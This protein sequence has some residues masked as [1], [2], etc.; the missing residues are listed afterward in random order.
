M[1]ELFLHWGQTGSGGRFGLVQAV[2]DFVEQEGERFKAGWF[3]PFSGDGGKGFPGETGRFQP[4]GENAF[5]VFGHKRFLELCFQAPVFAQFH[6]GLQ[7]KVAVAARLVVVGFW[8]EADVKMEEDFVGGDVDQILLGRASQ[9]VK[10]Y[11]PSR[12][13]RLFRLPG[14]WRGEMIHQANAL[15]QIKEVGSPSD[16]DIP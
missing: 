12:V 16:K 8:I 10:K 7:A 9:A 15:G 2:S 6:Q 1:R 13:C 3:Q 4:D 5:V 14:R 11:A